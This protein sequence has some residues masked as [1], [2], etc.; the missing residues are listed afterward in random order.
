MRRMITDK[1]LDNLKSTN[2]KIIELDKS[3]SEA[4]ITQEQM[5]IFFPKDAQGNI[6]KPDY[7]IV[8]SDTLTTSGNGGYAHLS[9][10]TPTNIRFNRFGT[11]SYYTATIGP[12][13]THFIQNPTAVRTYY[14]HYIYIK[15]S[16]LYIFLTIVSSNNNHYNIYSVGNHI[17]DFHVSC[18]GYLTQGSQGPITSLCY[19]STDNKF[20]YSLGVEGKD[21]AFF[22]ASNVTE[23]IDEVAGIS[24]N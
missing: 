12:N 16:E 15:T 13:D 19:R 5:D 3:I 10:W 4:T 9:F 23:C 6:Y 11:N 24:V 21:Y 17:K 1:Q 8:I 18:S 14:L 2:L 20:Y 7:D 22:E